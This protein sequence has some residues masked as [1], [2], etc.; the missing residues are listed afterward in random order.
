M[1][2]LYPLNLVK[3]PKLSLNPLYPLNLVPPEVQA[4]GRHRWRHGPGWERPGLRGKQ[5]MSPA[6]LHEGLGFRI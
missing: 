1:Q 4:V 2:D 5:R 3:G 6:N